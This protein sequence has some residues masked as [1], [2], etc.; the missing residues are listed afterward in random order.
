M[1][2]DADDEQD[3]EGNDDVPWALGGVMLAEW[4]P[5]T[6]LVLCLCGCCK[7]GRVLRLLCVLSPQRLPLRLENVWLS[8]LARALCSCICSD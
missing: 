1:S 3:E 7:N 5:M 2:A 4:L 6:L 8:P